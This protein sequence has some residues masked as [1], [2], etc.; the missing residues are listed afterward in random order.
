MYLLGH[1]GE[2]KDGL[3]CIITV[4]HLEKEDADH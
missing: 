4:Q 3:D 2:A 1:N